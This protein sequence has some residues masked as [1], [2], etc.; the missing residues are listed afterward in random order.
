EIGGDEDIGRCAAFDL[1][2][3]RAARCVG[4]GDVL[5]PCLVGVVERI[6]HAGGGENRHLFL[7]GRGCGKAGQRQE[8]GGGRAGGALDPGTAVDGHDFPSPIL[9]TRYSSEYLVGWIL[10]SAIFDKIS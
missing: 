10:A 1:L 7:R 4:D 2:G 3:E 9:K 5:T 8:C 6:L